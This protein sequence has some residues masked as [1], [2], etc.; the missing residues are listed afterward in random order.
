MS[1]YIYTYIHANSCELNSWGPLSAPMA[2]VYMC[3]YMSVVSFPRQS[4]APVYLYMSLSIYLYIYVYTLCMCIITLIH[5]T[6]THMYICEFARIYV[7]W[8]YIY[9]HAYMR[10][11]EC[12]LMND[13]YVR[14]NVKSVGK[15]E[16][17][18]GTTTEGLLKEV[19]LR[20]DLKA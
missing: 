6:Y 12:E 20:Q 17:S 3:I 9:I 11:R 8:Y 16:R 13:H 19:L 10:V 2:H 18:K 7:Y 14:Q 1:V 5:Y 15:I 4:W